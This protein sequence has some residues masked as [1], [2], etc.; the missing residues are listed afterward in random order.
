MNSHS[1]AVD[2]VLAA[3]SVH[4]DRG[5]A[6]PRLEHLDPHDR[7]I[8]ADLMRLMETGRR[9]DPAASAPS[10]EAL[11][12]GTEFADALPPTASSPAPPVLDQLRDV[13]IEVDPRAEVI[14]DPEGFVSFAY[15]DLLARFHLV[16]SYEPTL[17]DHAIKALF[18]ADVDVD[19]IGL[20]AAETPEL[21][22]RVVS[23]Y[24]VDT[25]VTTAAGQPVT[26]PPALPAALAAR[27]IMEHSAPEWGVSGLGSGSLDDFVDVASLA[28][29]LA[30]KLVAEEAKR[31]YQGDKAL[32]YRSLVGHEHH[33]AELVATASRPREVPFDLDAEVERTARRVA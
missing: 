27:Q 19:L 14:A 25:T 6:R 22:T 13:L 5:T 21:L 24:D 31:R 11:L 4:L 16:N 23:R 3:F 30:T 17:G 33:L 15:L 2:A 12:A 7:Q 20:V 26:P 32:A 28:A 18:N 9:I 8:A 10:L 29:H 1:D